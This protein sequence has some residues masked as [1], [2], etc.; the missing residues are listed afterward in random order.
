MAGIYVHIPF[1]QQKC[2]YCDF[3]KTTQI[4]FTDTFLSSL[5]KEIELTK[6]YLQN[7][8]VNTVYFGGGT[9]SVLKGLQLYTIL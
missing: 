5:Q 8:P 6:N 1:C 2:N 3:Y 7:K 4:Q 9:P